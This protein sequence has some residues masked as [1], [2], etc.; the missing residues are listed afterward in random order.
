MIKLA[1]GEMLFSALV[2]T[3]RDDGISRPRVHVLCDLIPDDWRVEFPRKLREEN[4]IGSRFRADLKVCQ[5]TNPDGSLRG[6]PYLRADTNTI[7]PIEDY[8]PETAIRAIPRQGSKDP[9]IYDYFGI[10]KYKGSLE[11]LRETAKSVDPVSKTTVQQSTTRSRNASIK[12]Y[13]LLRAAG[14]CEK[15]GSPAPFISRSGQPYLEVHH[16]ESLEGGGNDSI[17]NTAAICPNCHAEVTRG[18]DADDINKKLLKKV[19]ALEEIS[20]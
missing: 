12:A 19:I 11:E 17:Y 13:V 18:I 9:R 20:G 16:I 7:I 8:T 14:I 4:P 10:D 2:E 15:C 5:K 6:Q 1:V 3:C